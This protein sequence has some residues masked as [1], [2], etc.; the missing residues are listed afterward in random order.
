[1]KDQFLK[2][3]KVLKTGKSFYQKQRK[4]CQNAMKSESFYVS[5]YTGQYSHRST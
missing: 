4:A 1:M 3:N 2:L 5:S